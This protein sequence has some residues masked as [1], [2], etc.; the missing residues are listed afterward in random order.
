MPG[1][2]QYIFCCLGDRSSTAVAGDEASQNTGLWYWID[3]AGNM[4]RF[5]SFF[6]GQ[7]LSFT[8]LFFF[9]GCHIPNILFYHRQKICR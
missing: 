9:S 2:L 5:Y 1:F 8:L 6:C 7:Y 4:K 3:A